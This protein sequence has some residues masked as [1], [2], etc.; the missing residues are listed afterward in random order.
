M[1][2]FNCR[3]SSLVS[4]C[5]VPH[6]SSHLRQ[7]ISIHIELSSGYSH[8]R[9]ETSFRFHIITQLREWMTMN[10]ENRIPGKTI[11]CR[12]ILRV[13]PSSTAVVSIIEAYV[14]M[15]QCEGFPSHCIRPLY[16]YYTGVQLVFFFCSGVSRLF[17]AQGSPSSGSLLSLWVLVYD[18]SGC[19]SRFICLFLMIH[20]LVRDS[21]RGPNN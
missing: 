10:A 13:H 12:R 15:V 6:E 14:D 5:T 21:P 19:L 2:F 16:K 18:S 7:S 3:H 17:G 9:I 4:I 8:S 1:Y 20:W 11:F